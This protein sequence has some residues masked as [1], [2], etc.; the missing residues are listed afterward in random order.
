MHPASNR[1]GDRT[2]LAPLAPK[3]LARRGRR[4]AARRVS[5]KAVPHLP[6]D[7][8]CNALNVGQ[9]WDTDERFP[10]VPHCGAHAHTD[11]LNSVRHIVVKLRFKTVAYFP[12]QFR[13]ISVLWLR[14]RP[15][16]ASG[17]HKAARRCL[18]NLARTS[19]P[20]RVIC[21]HHELW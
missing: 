14:A 19:T 4:P 13:H 2:R 3:G 16:P 7:I 6:G 5:G 10:V 17:A 8:R 21:E 18:M 9:A 1:T 12:E 11:L 15:A 20:R